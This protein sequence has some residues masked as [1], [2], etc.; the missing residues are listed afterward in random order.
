MRKPAS[1]IWRQIEAGEVTLTAAPE[2]SRDVPPAIDIYFGAQVGWSPARENGKVD[3]EMCCD[4]ATCEA[5]VVEA[6]ATC[7]SGLGNIE[8]PDRIACA[9]CLRYSRDA[10]IKA[11]LRDEAKGKK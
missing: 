11:I 4:L 8:L 5:I 1:S 2:P 7:L 10:E 9:S 6:C 3:L